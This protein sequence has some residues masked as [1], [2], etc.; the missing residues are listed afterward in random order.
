[1]PEQETEL[2]KAMLELAKKRVSFLQQ[3]GAAA[4]SEELV[5][6]AS[7]WQGADCSLQLTRIGQNV[8]L[9]GTYERN[10]PFGNLGL[11]SMSPPNAE[12]KLR[13]NLLYSGVMKGRA[14]IGQVTRAREG[15]ANVFDP[16]SSK[17]ILM[18]FSADGN[19]I[20]IMIDADTDSPSYERLR[21][22][23]LV[24]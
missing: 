8:Q 15:A 23:Q 20:Y 17:Q 2:N 13:Y 5:E 3:I 16:S 1:M 7:T 12:V 22:L 9:F 11:L 18:C 24:K 14:V 4:A 21:K 6:L 10:N 19:E